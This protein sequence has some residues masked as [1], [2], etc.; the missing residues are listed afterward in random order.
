M[1]IPR[2]LKVLLGLISITTTF[3]DLMAFR[4]PFAISDVHKW[5]CSVVYFWS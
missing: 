3:N 1:I 5:S 2:S 4:H